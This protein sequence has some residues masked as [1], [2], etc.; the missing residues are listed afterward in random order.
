MAGPALA[1][2]YRY[3][4]PSA[5]EQSS[6]GA[7][8]RLATCSGQGE[9]HPHFFQGRLRRP[10]RTADLLRSLINVVQSRFYLPPAMLARIFALADPIV[11]GSGDLLRF[12][13]FSGCCSTYGRVDLL[14]EAIDGTWHGRGTTNVDFNAPMR[15]ALSRVRDSDQVGLAVGSDEV[16]L[17]R[18]GESVVER[19]VTLPMRWIKGLAEVQAYQARMVHMLEVSGFEAARFLRSLPGGS[20]R[21]SGW[22]IS[23]GRGL[24]LSQV[25]SRGAIRLGGVERLHILD[26]L[27]RHAKALRIYA[28]ERN[29]ASAWELV[30]D[31]ARFTL[32]LSPE[33]SRGFSGEGQVLSDLA[34]GG[35]EQSLPRV[36]A[37]LKWSS[38]IEPGAVAA[39]CSF[40]RDTVT[41]ALGVLGPA[42]WSG[43]TWP[44]ARTFIANCPLTWKRSR[45]SSP[46]CSKHGSSSNQA[47][48]GSSETTPS[49]ARSRPPCRAPTSS[50][51][52]GSGPM[53]N[54]ALANGTPST[55]P[56]A[57]RASTS[58]RPRSRSKTRPKNDAKRARGAD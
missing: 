46:A 48:S 2:E 3:H 20:A 37:S 4:H 53:E 43:M 31:E 8:L 58:W 13:G 33:V 17:S 6:G 52:S 51:S 35:W 26:E 1:Y 21:T 34:A 44:R 5:L 27:A 39:E 36:H 49:R 16:S 50:I 15:A 25:A 47:A 22:V 7:N 9:P 40:D 56:S 32:V 14:P 57:G 28:D 10:G 24:R 38:R 19:K 18:A 54:A 11:T 12:E 42:A 41:A 55:A 30:L 45:P 29:G 23:S